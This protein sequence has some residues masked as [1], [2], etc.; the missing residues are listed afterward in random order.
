MKKALVFRHVS[1]EGLG[2]L[3]SF[4]K[5][6]KIA[7]EYC[8]L[9]SNQPVPKSSAGYDFIISM[10]GPMNVDETDRFPFLLAERKF[11]S[12]AIQSGK[13]VLGICLG[14]QMI[15]RALGASVYLG[16]Q[17]EI[18]WYSIQ[19]TEAGQKDHAFQGIT[20]SHPTVFQ[21]HGDTFDLPY[22]AM[23][24][25]SSDLFPHQAFQFKGIAYAFQFHIEMTREM[26]L[27]WLTKG[28]EEFKSKRAAGI[29]KDAIIR[30]I[31]KY[32]PRL[33]RFADAV[34]QEFFLQSAVNSNH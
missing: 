16:T 15:A 32:Q 2:T 7:I 22:G 23:L 1:H 17:K 20:G 34:F 29:S 8:D 13:P 4:L 5:R 30:D 27:D 9:F 28:E 31:E 25:A 19:L 18:G 11:I 24:L 6:S 14:A 21:W 33:H 3:E 26:I 12:E 10:G